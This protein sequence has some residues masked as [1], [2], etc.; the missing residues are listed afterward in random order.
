[1]RKIRS[2]A[3][4]FLS[5]NSP[6]RSFSRF[7]RASCNFR[8]SLSFSLCVRAVFSWYSDTVSL[9]ASSTSCTATVSSFTTRQF[10]RSS[11]ETLL[12][13]WWDGKESYSVKLLLRISLF[14]ELSRC[15]RLSSLKRD[16]S[17][18]PK[19]LHAGVVSLFSK[20]VTIHK[21]HKHYSLL[22][23]SKNGVRWW[24]GG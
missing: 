4:G 13:L 19:W 7:F 24:C 15:T 1:M 14:F 22:L 20:I 23:W 8:R 9:T 16:D 11:L 2:K 6:S 10:S 18:P 12:L 5:W 21:V 3:S 17:L